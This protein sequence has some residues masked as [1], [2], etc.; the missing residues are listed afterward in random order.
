MS[1][2]TELYA[3]RATAWQAA[4]DF[5]DSHGDVLSAEDAQ[6]Y[7]RMEADITSMTNQIERLQRAQEMDNVMRQPTSTPIQDKPGAGVD[8]TKTGTAADAY[9]NAFWRVMKDKHAP[10]EVVNALQIGTDTEG[11]YLVPDEYEKKLVDGLT[12]ENIIRRLAHTI[13]TANG[14]RKIPLVTSHGTADWIDEEGAYIESDD[15]FGQ[16]TLSAYKLGTMIK[17]SDELLHDS[18]F[19]L[20]TYIS[21]EFVRRIAAAEEAAFLTG[22]GT[23]RPTGLLTRATDA[24]ETASATAVTADEIID[25]VYALKAPYRR[26]AVLLMN[27]STIKLV[28]K[29]KAQANGDYIWQPGLQAG[30]P[31]RILGYT[32]YTSP[33]MPA[34]AAG[35][36]AI[37]FG[38]FSYYWVADREGR[39][40][41]RL[42]EL[43][44]VNGQVG[45]LASERVDGNLILPEAIVTLKGK[46]A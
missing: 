40:F 6:Q 11:G 36:K 45:F 15:T 46:T 13:R 30:Q 26:K 5:L 21:G 41:K 10:Y 31:D 7:D 9:N 20:P 19:N 28:R 18:V 37:A 34:L 8:A 33:E 24:V 38:D 32:V 42:N 1:K 39:R 23:G 44:A 17:V 4:K 29:L 3:K 14:D 35:K 22:N 12:E 27:D 43:Y 25:L 2:L 16:I